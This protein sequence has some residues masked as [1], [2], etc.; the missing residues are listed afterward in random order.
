[1]VTWHLICLLHLKACGYGLRESLRPGR[2]QVHFQISPPLYELVWR[3]DNN[4]ADFQRTYGTRVVVVPR[5][6][7]AATLVPVDPVVA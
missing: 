6:A 4:M 2:E 5:G 7:A 3:L 1:M